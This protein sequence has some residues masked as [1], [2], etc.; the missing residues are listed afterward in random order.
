MV[1][2]IMNVSIEEDIQVHLVEV[3]LVEGNLFSGWVVG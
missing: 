3:H 2:T 1:A